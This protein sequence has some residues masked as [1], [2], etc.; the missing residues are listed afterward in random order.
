METKL[1]GV[2]GDQL[3]KSQNPV[4]TAMQASLGKLDWPGNNLSLRFLKDPEVAEIR[5]RFFAGDNFPQWIEDTFRTL[6]EKETK[7]LIID[8]RGNGGGVDMYGATLVSFLT[9][10]PF[11][12]FDHLIAKT[13]AV[14]QAP[15]ISCL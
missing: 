1:A 5:V 14:R 3:G 2:T 13:I 11:R 9:D 15:A 4:N 12:Y 10:K 7:A 8:L 6:R